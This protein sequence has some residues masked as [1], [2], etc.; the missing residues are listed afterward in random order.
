[1]KRFHCNSLET[2]SVSRRALLSAG[3][4]GM[5]GM[6]VADFLRADELALPRSKVTARAKSVIFLFQW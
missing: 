2:V 1:M 4:M 3:G 5:L 6:N